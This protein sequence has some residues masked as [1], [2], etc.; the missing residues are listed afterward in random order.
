MHLLAAQDWLEAMLFRV[1]DYI[2]KFKHTLQHL[3]REWYNGLDMDQF[4]SNL[5]EFTRHFSRYFSTQERNIKHLHERW[6]SFS[7]DPNTDDIEEYIHNVHEAAKQLEHGDD[8][9]L[10]LLKAT[11]PT[12]LY[13]TLYGH[14]NLYIVM[15]MLKDIYAK[16]PQPA[17]AVATTSQGATAPLTLMCAPTRT[18]SKAQDESPL[19]ERVA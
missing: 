18:S 7:F 8:A 10:N 4:G 12:E 3:A 19:E 11:T 9:V 15:T 6:R 16:K 14:D 13:G 5:S 2:K 1:D 17:A